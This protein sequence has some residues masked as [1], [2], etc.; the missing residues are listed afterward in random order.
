MQSVFQMM[1]LVCSIVGLMSVAQLATLFVRSRV[2][3]ALDM[4]KIGTGSLSLTLLSFFWFS[5]TDFSNLFL[6]WFQIHAPIAGGVFFA[7]LLAKRRDREA[8]DSLDEV[9]SR[10]MMRMKEGRSLSMSLDLVVNEI[11]PSLRPRWLEIARSVSFSP[12]KNIIATEL[13]SLPLAEI[14]RELRRVDQMRRSQLIELERWRL[15]VRT[16]FTFR[17]RSV[18]AMAQVRAQSIVL[19]A[20]YVLIALFSMVAF[21]W[22][23]TK[24]SFHISVPIFLVGLFVIWRS[25]RSVKWSV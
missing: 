15:R 23:A 14:A 11:R 17:R 16:E 5:P 1:V 18:Q 13:K 7:I 8:V 3:S 4:T 19:S 21:G 2:V 22:N 10:L 24:P 25:G 6:I 20:I 9:L 12:Q